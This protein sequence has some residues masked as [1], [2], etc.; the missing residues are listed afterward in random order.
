MLGGIAANQN[1]D[2][3]DAVFGALIH[4]ARRRVLVTLFFH[5]GS[6]TAGKIAGVFERAWQATGPVG[7][8]R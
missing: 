6:M 3:Y 1:A 5:G 4:A 8:L 7:I 2:A